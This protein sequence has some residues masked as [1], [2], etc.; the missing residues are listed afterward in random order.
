MIGSNVRKE[1]PIIA[2]RLRKAAMANHAKISFV[3]PRAFDWH[4]P[5]AHEC[6]SST[7]GMLDVLAGIAKAAYEKTSTAAPAHLAAS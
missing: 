4:L 5:V 1:Q 2:H 7:R 3:N 6:V